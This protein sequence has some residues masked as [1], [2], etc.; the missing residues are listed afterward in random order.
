MQTEL[1]VLL[2][3]ALPQAMLFTLAKVSSHGALRSKPLL[4]A[5]VLKQNTVL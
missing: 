5:Q 2:P 4:L 1:V 3:D